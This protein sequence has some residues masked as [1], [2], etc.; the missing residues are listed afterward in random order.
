MKKWLWAGAISLVVLAGA[1][2]FR[3]PL[4]LLVAQPQMFS[5]PVFDTEP[6]TVPPLTGGLSVLVLTKTNGFRHDS[7]PDAVRMLQEISDGQGWGMFHTENAAVFNR[8][9]LAGFDLVVLA[10]A[11][12]PLFTGEQETAFR[13]FI[14]GGGGVVAMHAAGD[15]SHG[16]GWYTSELI[17]TTMV[18]HPMRQQFQ[19]ATLK[20]EDRTHPATRHLADRWTRTDEWYN[21]AASPRG[22]VDVLISIDEATYDPEDRP[23]GDD[24]P[25]V[26]SRTIGKGRVLYSAL[27]HSSE[28]YA[29]PE[30]RQLIEG[31]MVWAA[32]AHQL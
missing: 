20:V 25:M 4:Y 10:S 30:H 8:E 15:S 24:H 5:G 26:W 28:S 18:G 29:E 2:Q 14:E 27:G 7:I 22:L 12:G 17:G 19:A 23:M 32:M 21:F 31:A 13:G 3:V 1:W 9:D 11:S 6:P 16:P